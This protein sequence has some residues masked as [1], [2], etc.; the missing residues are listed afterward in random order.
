MEEL[1]KNIKFQLE[2]FELGGID[3]WELIKRIE[4]I[5]NK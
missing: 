5:V 1:K 2:E 3:V 4:I